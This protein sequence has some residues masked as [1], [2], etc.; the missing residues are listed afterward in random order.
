MFTTGIVSVHSEH[1]ITKDLVHF[2]GT[3]NVAYCL[4]VAFGATHK[5]DQKTRKIGEFIFP[6][7]LKLEQIF[8]SPDGH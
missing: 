4:Y 3:Q 7:F 6:E 8:S 2:Q 5:M 1:K